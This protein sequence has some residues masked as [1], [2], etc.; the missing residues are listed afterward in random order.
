M[1]C[2]NASLCNGS[3]FSTLSAVRVGLHAWMLSDANHSKVVRQD[4]GRTFHIFLPNW[5]LDQLKSD[6][7]QICPPFDNYV[8]QHDKH[9]KRSHQTQLEIGW[10]WFAQTGWPCRTEAC[11]WEPISYNYFGHT[12]RLCSA[13]ISLWKFPFRWRWL[14]TLTGNEVEEGGVL[15]EQRPQGTQGGGDR[16]SQIAKIDFLWAVDIQSDGL[17]LVKVIGYLH[18][19]HN[20]SRLDYLRKQ[21]KQM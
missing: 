14:R 19:L 13:S 7:L 2:H 20:L 12:K 16:G 1:G 9:V 3:L 10:N 5:L 18:N 4:D 6:I 15:S 8:S 17:L 11:R 21:C